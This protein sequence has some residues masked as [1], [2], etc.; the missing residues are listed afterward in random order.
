MTAGCAPQRRGAP[1]GLTRAG[2]LVAPA[3]RI[4]QPH[5]PCALRT[6]G[7]LGSAGPDILAPRSVSPLAN[8]FKGSQVLS[9]PETA[10]RA[11]GGLQPNLRDIKGQESAKRALEVAAAAATTCS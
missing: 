10:L 8:H 7:G 5:L 3:V 9:R 6:R 2:A 4:G 11:A 1:T